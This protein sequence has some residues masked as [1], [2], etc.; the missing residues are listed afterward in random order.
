MTAIPKQIIYPIRYLSVFS[1]PTAGHE[2]IFIGNLKRQLG[3]ETHVVTLGRARAGIYLLVKRLLTDIR[4]RV[5]LSPYTIPDVVNMV[6]FAGA[7]PVFVDCVCRS[8]NVDISQ[9][10]GLIDDRTACVMITH[11]H[12]NQDQTSAIHSLCRARGVTLIDDCAIAFGGCV[13]G[14]P[15]GNATDASVFSFSGFKTLNFFWGGV[16]T[17]RSQPLAASLHDET[18]RWPRLRFDQYRAQVIKT[19]KYSVATSGALFPTIV[20]PLLRRFVQAGEIRDILPMSRI[21]SVRL[22]ETILSRPSLAA[23]VEWNRKLP[24]VNQILV[25]RRAI[26]AIYDEALSGLAVGGESSICTKQGSTY[27]NYPI[28]VGAQRNKIYKEI[29]TRGFDVGLSLYPNVHEMSG[30]ADVEGRVTRVSNLVRSVITLPTHTRVSLEY[31]GRLRECVTNV[32]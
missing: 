22:D 7:E 17:T 11:Y 5:I 2:S 25:H 12:L 1:S 30:Y 6:K 13:D 9:L 16:V 27:V 3:V 14:Q 31:A 32:L 10:S 26:A 19:G 15:V 29:L 28:F 20:F 24:S 23:V 8:T 18:R 4:R 21:E